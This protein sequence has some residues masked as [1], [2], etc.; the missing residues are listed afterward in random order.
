[1]QQNNCHSNK[2]FWNLLFHF[3]WQW[4]FIIWTNA[5]N[6][7][8]QLFRDTYQTKEL[9][10]RHSSNTDILQRHLTSRAGVSKCGAWFKILLRGPTQWFVEIF[11]GVHGVMIEISDVIKTSP[12][13]STPRPLQQRLQWI[14]PLNPINQR[15][16]TLINTSSLASH[17]PDLKGLTSVVPAERRGIEYCASGYPELK[18]SH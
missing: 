14:A 4:S 16:T 2:P 12:E 11:E 17:L 6:N 10:R 9:Q 13:K 7:A 3:Y 5:K 8:F 15:V 1:M 18:S